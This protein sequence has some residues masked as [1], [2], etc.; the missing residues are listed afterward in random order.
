[1]KNTGKHGS[2]AGGK[3]RK[4]SGQ[5]SSVKNLPKCDTPSPSK[6]MGGGARPG[7]SGSGGKY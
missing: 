6:L 2:M 4:P 1:M 3:I 5:R 7:G